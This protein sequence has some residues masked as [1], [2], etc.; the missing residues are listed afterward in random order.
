MYDLDLFCSDYGFG[1]HYGDFCHFIYVLFFFNN[2]D[3]NEVVMLEVFWDNYGN[4]LYEH[5]LMK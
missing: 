3:S 4:V 2:Q 5:V 1:Y